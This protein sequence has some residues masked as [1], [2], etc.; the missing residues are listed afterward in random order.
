MTSS[1]I[2][3]QTISFIVVLSLWLLLCPQTAV[4][5]TNC[6]PPAISAQYAWPKD[7]QVQ[8]N[9]DSSF[10]SAQKQGIATALANWNS[11]NGASGNNS[12]VT[13]LPP[14]Y[15]STPLSG[16]N[17]MQVTNQPPPTCPT[18]PGTADGD[19]TGASRKNALISLNGNQANNLSS[20]QIANIMAHE[21]GHTFGLDNCTNCTCGNPQGSTPDASVMSTNCGQGQLS[22][23]Q[24]P[25]T[26]DNTKTNAVGQYG[27]GGG[28]GGGCESIDADGDGWN[29]CTDCNDS[30]YDPLN[31]CGGSCPEPCTPPLESG[32]GYGGA[33]FCAYPQTGCPS[34]A[35]AWQTCCCTS[36]PI[37]ID[38]SGNGLNLTNGING[39]QFDINGDGRVDHPS[40]TPANSDNAWLALDRNG[41]GIIDDGKELFG[42]FT[43][44]PPSPDRNG[45]LALAEFDKRANGGNRDGVIDARDAIFSSLLLWQD[46]N[47]NGSSESAELHALPA[48]GLRSIELYYRESRRVDQYGNRFRYRAKV[49]DAQG[50]QV[51]RWAWDVFLV[52]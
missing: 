15:N 7:A 45:F 16:T 2:Q 21:V 29:S 24:G 35:F 1:R 48:L 10:S 36:C 9:I 38:I 28:G 17:T 31:N 8:V 6:Q 41:N 37:L 11:A 5:Q 19:T 25:T 32:C 22:S 14:T 23:P 26:C 52:P 34:P 49:R 43:P 3:P 46:T 27:S 51:G 13:F 18:C 47:H 39:V 12:G 20:W 50:A 33:D 42:N 4:L 30:N 40:W 44:Q